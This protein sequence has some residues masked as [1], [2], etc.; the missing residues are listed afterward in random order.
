MLAKEQDHMRRAPEMAFKGV[1][2]SGAQTDK[3]ANIY[4]KGRNESI[5]FYEG[6]EEGAYEG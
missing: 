3:Q 4:Q 2:I 6:F 1:S 5:K